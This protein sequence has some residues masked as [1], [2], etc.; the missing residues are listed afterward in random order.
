MSFLNWLLNPYVEGV[1]TSS[2]SQKD[3]TRIILPS[4]SIYRPETF[5]DYIGQNKAKNIIKG[6]IEGTQK[7]DVI[8]PHTLISGSPGFGKTSLAL[9]IALYLK[10]KYVYCIGSDIESYEDIIDR[11]EKVNGGIIFL[12]EIHSLKRE[13]AEKLYPILED[14]RGCESVFTLV[15]ATTELGEIIK[16]RKP[17]FDRFKI[18]IELEKYTLEDLVR[19]V[20]LYKN[21]LFNKE[22]INNKCYKLLA[23]N[24]RGTPRNLIR[25]LE[26]L[27]YLD[28]NIERVLKNFS[29]IKD[30]YTASDLK[31][32]EY[33]KS[34]KNVVGLNS[35]SNYLDTSVENYLYYIEP[36]LLQTDII[37]RTSK[38]R[39][40]TEKGMNLIERLNN[41]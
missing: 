34:S 5:D 39:R 32:L 3:K 7:R 25:L 10:V 28:G 33:I 15:G 24:C 31:I 41:A 13:M 1:C 12:D 6:Y 40:L 11:I 37:V 17:F 30:G 38:G 20:C 22:N 18:I 27:V 21:R 29:I 8:F 19:M 23:E 16:D 26:S 4:K 35:L 2:T 9:L 14:F 36:Y